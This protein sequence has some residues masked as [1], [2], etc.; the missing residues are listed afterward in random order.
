MEY[1]FG[2]SKCPVCNSRKGK[3]QCQAHG[4]LVCSLCCG[5]SRALTACHGCSFYEA[6]ER[7]Y[8][9]LPRYS[10]K[11]MEDSTEL[12]EISFP[13]EAAVCS[14]DRDH[15]FVLRDA[16]AI[17]IFELLLD[18]YAFGDARDTVAARIAAL[19]CGSV[20]DLVE[21]E[22]RTCDRATIAKVI[23]TVRFVACRRASGGRGH[24]E[25]LHRYCGSFV[26]KG[27][28]LR[29]LDDGTEVAVGQA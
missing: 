18:L 19:D 4:A 17:A 1:A 24:L 6:P 10:T 15:G 14:L 22:L 20:V 12:R 26:T 8:G 7:R 13:V 28:G 16:Q 3:R 23:A 5:T 2:M 11:E 9:E 25:L 27:V 21:C 29:I